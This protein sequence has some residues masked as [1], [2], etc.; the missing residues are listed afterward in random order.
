MTNTALLEKLIKESGLKKGYL[1]KKANMSLAWLRAC[2]KNEGEFREGQMAAIANELGITE[3]TLFM[4]V[5]FA[6][7]G[8]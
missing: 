7:D 5:F 6:H 4:A 8:A 3:P 1:A 2:I